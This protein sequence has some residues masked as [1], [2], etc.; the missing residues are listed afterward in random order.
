MSFG[1][2]LLSVCHYEW[3]LDTV[4]GKAMHATKIFQNHPEQQK[5]VRLLAMS[6]AI[7]RDLIPGPSFEFAFSWLLYF[8][9]NTYLR[10]FLLNEESH[11]T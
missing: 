9:F 7:K 5:D 3:C 6:V 10:I 4:S 1:N 2:S 11:L 8:A